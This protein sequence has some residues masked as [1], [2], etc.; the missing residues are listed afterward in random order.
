MSI[1]KADRGFY[2]CSAENGVGKIVYRTINIVVEFEPFV[3]TPRAYQGHKLSDFVYL[4]CEIEAYPTPSIVWMH[5]EIELLS[6]QY[7]T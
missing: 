6:N 5:R 2:Y 4:E 7:H 1:K 3:S